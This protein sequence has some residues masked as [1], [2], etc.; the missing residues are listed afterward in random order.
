MLQ[1]TLLLAADVVQGDAPISTLLDPGY[2]YVDGPLAALYGFSA[3]PSGSPMVKVMDDGSGHRSGVLTQASVL[4]LTSKATMTSAVRRGKYVLT[5][6]L[7]QAPPPPPPQVNTNLAPTPADVTNGLTSRE[8]LNEHV[9]NPVCAACHSLMDPIGF[10]LDNYDAIGAWRST[11]RV[12]TSSVPIDTSAT[13]PTGETFHD[14]HGLRQQIL[15][16]RDS[17]YSC[18]DATLLSA[19]LDVEPDTT[20]CELAAITKQSRAGEDRV[21]AI[22]QALA[23]SVSFTTHTK[24]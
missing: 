7:C 17:F 6:L 10:G 19:A 9:S 15:V 23:T 1:E 18:L 2:T 14:A 13:L 5:N 12:G 24:E 22:V 4:T 21:S 20:S 8:L 11:E 3:V 16:G